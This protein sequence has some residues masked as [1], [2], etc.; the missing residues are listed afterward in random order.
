MTEKS[1]KSLEKAMD[2]LCLFDAEHT[3]LSAQEISHRMNMRPSSTYRYLDVMLRK[4]FLAKDITRTKYKLGLTI[5]KLGNLAGSGMRLVDVALP[6]MKKL[7]DTSR[8]SILLTVLSDHESI[9]LE[10]IEAQQMIKLSMERG[11]SLPLHAAASSRILLAFQDDAFVDDW[12]AKYGLAKLTENTITD[13]ALLKAELQK[14]RDQG[15]TLSIGEADTGAAAVAAPIFDHRAKIAGG[16]TIAG[17]VERI[18]PQ[19]VSK[20]AAM[21]ISA[22]LN[23]SHDLGYM[24]GKPPR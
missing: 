13:L 7:A 8:E 15:Y 22:A 4:G 9:C 14:T 11:S 16:L 17:P 10:K 2:I 23:I 3:E 6:H 20:L 1:F 19:S 18:K 12:V 5:F 24:A 21:V